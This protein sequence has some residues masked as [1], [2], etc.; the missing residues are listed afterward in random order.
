MNW[1]LNEEGTPLRLREGELMAID[2]AWLSVERGRVWVTLASDPV[3]HFLDSGHAIRLPRGARAIVGAE[4]SAEL[5]LMR[6]PGAL[7]RALR[8]ITQWLLARRPLKRR[9]DRYQCA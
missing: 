1:N 9:R 8:R 3:D 6:P 2:E 7:Q 4:G 5:T